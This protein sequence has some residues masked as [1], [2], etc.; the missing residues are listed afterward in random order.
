[1]KFYEISQNFMNSNEISQHNMI[2][3]FDFAQFHCI[4]LT[5]A[6][7]KVSTKFL[8]YDFG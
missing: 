8:L 3:Y 5:F 6:F 7:I 1:M 2:Y 4:S